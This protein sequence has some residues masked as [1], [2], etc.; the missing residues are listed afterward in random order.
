MSS[1]NP[2]YT[3]EYSQPSEYRFSHD[4]VFL[5]R[6]VFEILRDEQKTPTS[7]LDLC[8][9]CG[10]IG[11]DFLFHQRQEKQALPDFC[12]FLEIQSSYQS[13]FQENLRRFGPTKTDLKFLEKNYDALKETSFTNKYDLIITNPPYFIAQEG[14]LST[15]E[16]K[17]RC[18]FFLDSTP[19]NL[20]ACIENSLQIE[21][22]AFV[23]SRRDLRATGRLQIE[24]LPDIR[25]TALY[26]FIKIR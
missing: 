6:R 15:S 4:S 16:F 2:H 10:I 17:N 19:E 1:I 11:L 25:G 22:S 3:F 24:K 26:R 20:M 7:I 23:L 14:T 13:H 12:D 5:A 18:R 8:S 9:G 21:G